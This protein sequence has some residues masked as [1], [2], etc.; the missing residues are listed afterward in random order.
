[1]EHLLTRIRN[2]AGNDAQAGGHIATAGVLEETLGIRDIPL[3]EGFHLWLT[4]TGSL[5]QD[6]GCMN[7]NEV[8][9]ITRPRDVSPG[10]R[11]SFVVITSIN[12]PTDGLL[13]CINFDSALWW[14][15]KAIEAAV[16]TISIKTN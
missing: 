12:C 4:F 5:K 2:L 9:N 3:R 16:I 7:A 10:Y 1:M 15:Y 6:A 8:R 13:Q 14:V 11:F